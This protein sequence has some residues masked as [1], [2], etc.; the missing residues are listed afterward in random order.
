MIKYKRVGK[1]SFED[2]KEDFVGYACGASKHD[3]WFAPYTTDGACD[4]RCSHH[5]EIPYVVD[6]I[7]YYE[8]MD[9][10]PYEEDSDEYDEYVD[11][12]IED[13]FNAYYHDVYK[14]KISDEYDEYCEWVDEMN[15]LVDEQNF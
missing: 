12:I 5:V 8:Y 9:E 7:D 4:T 11:K 14:D 6:T 13:I 3:L 10:C 15:S 2:F 1:M